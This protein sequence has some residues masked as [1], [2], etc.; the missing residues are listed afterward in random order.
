[1]TP[2]I[3]LVVERSREA[4][5][6]WCDRRKVSPYAPGLCFVHAFDP[7]DNERRLPLLGD[8]PTYLVIVEP[9]T[10]SV[11]T[12]LRRYGMDRDAD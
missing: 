10:E 7:D 5:E 9:P 1:M 11:R 6:Q 8:T 4:F 2:T 3:H 12:Q